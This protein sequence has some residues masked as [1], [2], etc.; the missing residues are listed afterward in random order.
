ML[1]T[2]FN[3][4]EKGKSLITKMPIKK[5]E[6]LHKITNYN[7]ITSATY[8]SVQISKDINIE[9]LYLAHLN[10]SC[11]PNIIIDTTNLEISALK[12]IQSNEELTFFYPSTEWNMSTPFTCKCGASQCLRIITGAKYLSID[13][14]SH[15]FINKH[16]GAIALKCLTQLSYEDVLIES[17]SQQKHEHQAFPVVSVSR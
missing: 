5:G 12:D 1:E 10:H 2:R 14:L 7:Q 3:T 4:N 6:V 15:Y 16:I 9:E 8:T 11:D 17:S 13:V